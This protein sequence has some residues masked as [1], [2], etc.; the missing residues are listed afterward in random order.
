[1]G[2]PPPRYL[3]VPFV[4]PDGVGK[5]TLLQALG[6]HLQ[7]RDGLPAPPVRAVQASGSTAMVLD[8]RIARGFLQHV[9]FPSAE[10]EDA[11]LGATPFQGAVLVVSATDSVLPGT[12]RSLTHAREAG[13]PRVAVALTKCD[14]V[15]D[16]EMLDLVTMEIRE[17]LNKHEYEGDKAPVACVSAVPRERPDERDVVALAG[18]LDAVDRW[19]P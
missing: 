12:L 2:Q 15:E 17:L 6:L 13:I 3:V 5:T 7:R 8:A 1:M 11:L 14:L 10:V 9:D 19:I 4:G 18:L 16:P